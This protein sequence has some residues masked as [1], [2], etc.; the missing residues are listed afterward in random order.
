MS[1]IPI[2]EAV[3]SL[4]IVN[5]ITEDQMKE[6]MKEINTEMNQLM[7][8]QAKMNSYFRDKKR[9]EKLNEHKSYIGKCFVIKNDDSSNK[10]NYIKAFKIIDIDERSIDYALCLCLINGCRGSSEEYGVQI[11]TIGL[12]INNVVRMIPKPEDPKI[13]DFYK[14][15]KDKEFCAMYETY[16][17]KLNEK[18]F[19]V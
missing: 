17:E 2:S 18:A 19:C 13:I 9:Q 10:Y 1:D 8:E 12:W 14:E 3:K 15:V 7:E 11:M 5:G 16:R 6:R 4:K